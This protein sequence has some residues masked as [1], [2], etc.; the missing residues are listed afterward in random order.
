MQKNY[1]VLN[2]AMDEE[3]SF[4]LAVNEVYDSR[5]IPIGVDIV[6]GSPQRMQLVEWWLGRSIPASREF[7]RE[8]LLELRFGSVNLLLTKSL[9][10]SLTDQYWLKPEKKDFKWEQINYFDNVFSNDIGNYLFD[11]TPPVTGKF[12]LFSPDTTS[13]GNL[14]KKWKI[15]NGERY[16]IKGGNGPQY[17]EPFN[18]VAA[19][20]IA[21]R[22]GIGHVNYESAWV[23]EQPVSVC[24]CFISRDTELVNASQLIAKGNYLYEEGYDRFVANCETLGLGNVTPFLD[25]MIVLD[26]LIVNTDRHFKNFGFLRNADTLEWLGPAPLFDNG[27]SFWN[28]EPEALVRSG[29]VGPCKT[30]RR[31][32]GE[33]IALVKDLSWLKL[34]ALQG[35]E[36]AVF[37]IMSANK[38]MGNEKS[39]A[40]AWAVQW[41]AGHLAQYVE[42]QKP[43]PP[44]PKRSLKPR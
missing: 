18:E 28:N 22:L 37:N 1:P 20:E 5:R 34:E 27:S 25:R 38:F 8:L 24:P 14:K 30:F 12:N 41:R 26:F 2:I 3:I 13:T 39:K 33:H 4:I 15:I 32:H 35:A 9:G 43:P 44:K 21:R 31:T 7:L 36:H 6:D 23:D 10:L 16:L 11:Y 40:L 17:Q 29:F 42:S 19:C